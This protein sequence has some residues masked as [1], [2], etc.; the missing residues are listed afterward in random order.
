MSELGQIY[1]IFEC[2]KVLLA[3]VFLM[4]LWPAVVFERHLKGKSKTYRFGFCM[5]ASVMIS[6][7]VV[8]GLGL[9][10][11]LRPIV[12][13]LLLFGSFAVVLFRN[14]RPDPMIFWNF[15]KALAG[16]MTFKG[17]FVDCFGRLFDVIRNGLSSLWKGT[18][19]RRLEYLLLIAV[20]IYG[21]II[22][23]YGAFDGHSY[24]SGDMFVHHKWIYDLTQGQA[25][26]GG[27]YPEA[28]HCVI[29]MICTSFRIHLY[30]GIL[31]LPGIH[32][33]VMLISAYLFMKELFHWPYTGLIALT[34]FLVFDQTPLDAIVSMARFAWTL[35]MEFAFFT[36]YFCA[37]TLTRY[38]KRVLRGKQTLIR[39]RS[40]REWLKLIQD[41]DLFLFTL[42]IASSIAVHFYATIFAFFYCLAVALVYLRQIFRK[43]SFVPL[44]AS[45]I[46]AVVISAAPMGA[47]FA[48]GYP[49]QGSIGWALSLI[50][51]SA[52]T[53]EPQVT[54][55]PQPTAVVPEE[56][57]TP[58]PNGEQNDPAPTAYAPTETGE[59]AALEE[60]S[61][62]ALPQAPPKPSIQEL[63][64]AL[65]LRGRNLVSYTVDVLYTN[66]YQGLHP[67]ERGYWIALVTVVVLAISLVMH[68][69][70]WFVDLILR[71]R[72][73]NKIKKNREEEPS[74]PVRETH[75]DYFD[76]YLTVVLLSIIMVFLFVPGKF[77]L[78][79]LI[80]GYRI[81]A[82]SQMLSAMIFALVPD[83]LFDGLGRLIP[84]LPLQ[85]LS[86]ALCA[87]VC[88]FAW[89]FGMF[90]GLLFFQMMRYGAAADMT[91]KIVE[92]MPKYQYTIISTTEELYQVIETGYHEELLTFLQR[93]NDPNY[94]LPTPYLFL[95]IE[96]KPIRYAQYHFYHGPSWIGWEKYAERFG[97]LGSQSPDVRCGEISPEAAEEGIR[98]G[99]KLSD[100]ATN[101]EGR[102]ILE[103]K[104][105]KWYREFSKMYPNEGSV[106]YEDDSFLCYC[107]TQNVNSLY[108]LGIFAQN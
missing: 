96:K 32:I 42:S 106:V 25:F 105:Y 27:V 35:P 4:Y 82:V 53:A 59:P 33:H 41:E 99:R 13:T 2:V 91:A 9:V 38:L 47:A 68:I 77:G 20:L 71:M 37:L 54:V 86:W 1:W 55:Q 74:K 19:G 94:T 16:T 26:G 63:A 34:M 95:Y 44:A 76:G 28:M 23:G 81:F 60:R 83:C 65:Y 92:T 46:L 80:E 36:P 8:L 10:H 22:F 58:I 6:N 64:H 50:T 104:A 84:K 107:I 69:L 17:F 72:E 108:T 67:G 98:Y 31:F 85:L 101:L 51:G 49:A 5:N 39:W 88:V 93:E 102:I 48:M 100:T 79:S 11:L 56:T 52:K 66:G 30:S 7:T 97:S 103:S 18:K 12:T 15:Q 78:P 45:V 87:G 89:Q 73:K 3:Y 70:L 90:H 24:G 57:T 62:E 61:G 75:R 40:P 29:Y 14:H 21:T 43:G